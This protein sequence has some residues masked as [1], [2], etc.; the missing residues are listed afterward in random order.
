[1]PAAALLPAAPLPA[2]RRA[3]LRRCGAPR[4]GRTA[5][6]LGR[7]VHRTALGLGLRRPALRDQ[8]LDQ[9]A[10]AADA[11]AADPGAGRRRRPDRP[12][13]QRTDPRPLHP[14][15][16][17]AGRA[18]RRPPVPAGTTGTDRR[19]GR[20]LP[21]GRGRPRRTPGP[22]RTTTLTNL[23]EEVSCMRTIAHGTSRC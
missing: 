17:A 16:A 3:H 19:G 8:W 21:R 5:P 18:G 15:R 6:R 2:H 10:V 11:A 4:P 9:P 22:A 7:A 20:R 23:K 14:A 1:G 13:G 12:A